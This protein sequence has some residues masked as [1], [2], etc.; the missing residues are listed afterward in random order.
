MPYA[1]SG[2][3]HAELWLHCFDTGRAAFEVQAAK[4]ISSPA[5]CCWKSDRSF[6][7]EVLLNP[8][9]ALNSKPYNPKP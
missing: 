1:S 9:L 2:V 6:Y 3:I 5:V 8:K 4:G 7:R